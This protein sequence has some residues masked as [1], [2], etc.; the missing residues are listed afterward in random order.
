MIKEE[1]EKYTGKVNKNI[2][3]N[4]V[5]TC[6]MD[7]KTKL[8]ELYVKNSNLVIDIGCGRCHDLPLLAKNGV[9]KMIGIEPSEC[10]FFSGIKKAKFLKEIKT[11]LIRGIGNKTWHNGDGAL[12]DKG[13]E[14]MIKL[15]K[16]NIGADMINMCWTIHYCMDTKQDFLNLFHNI[17]TNLVVGGKVMIL[18]MNGR[19]IHKLLQKNNGTYKN[20]VDGNTIFQLTSYYDHSKNKLNAYGNTIGVKLAGAYGLDNEIKENLVVSDFIIGF[21][22][23]NGYNLIYKNNFINF[24]TDNNIE[25]IKSYSIPQKKISAFYDIIIIEKLNK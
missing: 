19:L 4:P 25:C 15:F 18:S 14:T 21:F 5:K 11:I 9:K 10:S 24:A 7:I 13:K 8:I 2:Y 17:D 6:H 3:T 12:T 23:A 1:Y 20:I 22:K 16:N